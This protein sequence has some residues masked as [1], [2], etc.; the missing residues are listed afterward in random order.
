MNFKITISKKDVLFCLILGL[1]ISCFFSVMIKF[2]KAENFLTEKLNYYFHITWSL[3]III[4]FFFPIFSL[5]FFLFTFLL[6]NIKPVF[7]Q[8]GKFVL[9]GVLNTFVDWGVL[10]LFLNFTHFT[11]GIGY[12][13]LK[14]ISFIVANINS[15]F[16]N[17]FWTFKAT[18]VKQNPTEFLQFLFVSIGGFIINV[19]VA[20]SFVQ[21]FKRPINITPEIWAVI[22]AAIA[23][24]FSV[25]WNFA[26]YKIFVFKK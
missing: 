18:E 1:A 15:Y 11:S 21:L 20:T 25:A 24:L 14:G 2:I 10:T 7:H 16:W 12:S 9:V 26:G 22:G 17:K 4:F 8:L 5:L 23:T 13:F 6:G 3:S 19:G